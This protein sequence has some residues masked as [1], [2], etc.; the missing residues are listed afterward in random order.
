MKDVFKMRLKIAQ[1][2]IKCL[3]EGVAQA[4]GSGLTIKLHAQVL[5]SDFE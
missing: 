4:S 5:N 2:Y 1:N 3:K